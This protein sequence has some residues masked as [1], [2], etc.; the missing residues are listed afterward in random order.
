MGQGSY[1]ICEWDSIQ[2]QYP[3]FQAAFMECE[4]RAMNK[5]NLDWA[6]K[7]FNLANTFGGGEAEFGRTTI[8]PG[9]FIDHLG[10]AMATW[11][12]AFTAAFLAANP[13]QFTLMAGA[14]AGNT[15]PESI[16]I[17]IMGFAFPNKNQHI[18]EIKM[19]IGDRKYG[20][21]N[22]EEMGIMNK[23]A[24][25]LEEGIVLD[26]KEGFDLYAHFEG[27]IPSQIGMA[28]DPVLGFLHDQWTTLYQRV[29][30]IG[31]LYYQYYGK[32]GGIVGSA[33][34]LT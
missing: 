27:P 33:V 26:E 34:P 30:P 2:K 31:A 14:G 6:P 13:T 11:R 19:Q 22:L 17:A 4:G 25:I 3:A 15:I 8:L 7:R 9:A 12:Q 24:L 32:V 5:C 29:V 21:I 16:K 20:R 18:T 1:V 10:V 28:F 23:P